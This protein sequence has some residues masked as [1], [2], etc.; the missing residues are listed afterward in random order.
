VLKIDDLCTLYFTMK[1]TVVLGASPNP[2]R[3]SFKAVMSLQAHGHEVYAVGNKQGSVGNVLIDS[4]LPADLDIDTVTLYLNPT[5]QEEWK[6]AIMD[7]K[8]RRVIF[9]PGTENPEFEK[10]LQENG[11]QTEVACTLVLLSTDQY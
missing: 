6:S 8:P 1:K 7:T 9:N 5:R 10:V 4:Q 3:Y 11:I 2:D